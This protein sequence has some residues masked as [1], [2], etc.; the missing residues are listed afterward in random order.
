M[1]AVVV[2]PKVPGSGRLVGVPEPHP[3]DGEVLVQ[4]HEVGLDGTDAEATGASY[5]WALL[6]AQRFELP[7]EE[8]L[9]VED[10]PNGV[11]ALPPA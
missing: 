6:A 7:P 2:S 4:V 1:R 3:R 5:I 9:V 11:R 10:S 8:C